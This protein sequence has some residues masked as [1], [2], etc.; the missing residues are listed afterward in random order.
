MLGTQQIMQNKR[1]S[2]DSVVRPEFSSAKILVSLTMLYPH[3][4]NVAA[5]HF[6]FSPIFSHIDNLIILPRCHKDSF[7]I[8]EDQT[9]YQLSILFSKKH[10][11]TVYL[12][13]TCN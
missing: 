12:F 1:M 13:N 9:L 4:P 3:A 6:E 2:V 8:L 11:V 7:F 5:N 10:W